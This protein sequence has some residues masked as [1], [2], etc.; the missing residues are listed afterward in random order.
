E[1]KLAL[2]PGGITAGE[3]PAVRAVTTLTSEPLHVLVRPE[4]AERGFAALRGKRIDIG[5]VTHSSHH[6]ALEVL[7]LAGLTPATK[8]SPGGYLLETTV[9]EELKR[10]LE[11]IESLRDSDRAQATGKL[12]DAVV[13]IAPVPS[14]LAKHLVRGFGYKFLAL[15]FAEAFCLDRLNPP[16]AH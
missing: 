4:L 14:L 2:I 7:E 12:P 13:F 1:I 5:P 11:R 16:N 8:S 10:E 6:L 9:P 3:Y 15:P